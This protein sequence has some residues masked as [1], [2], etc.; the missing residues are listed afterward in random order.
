M[1]STEEAWVTEE[2]KKNKT[3]NLIG[4]HL[5]LLNILVVN[6]RIIISNDKP[7]KNVNLTVL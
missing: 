4:F 6:E 2:K 7:G 1:R 5:E 3:D